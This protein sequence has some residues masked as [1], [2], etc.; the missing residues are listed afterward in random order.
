MLARAHTQDMLGNAL[1]ASVMDKRPIDIGEKESHSDHLA[2]FKLRV[3][4]YY[5]FDFDAKK[6]G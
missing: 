2:E 5:D 4:K 1:R 6:V 3:A